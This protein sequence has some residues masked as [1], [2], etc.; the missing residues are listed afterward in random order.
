MVTLTPHP[1]IMQFNRIKLLL[2]LEFLKSKAE[3]QHSDGNFRTKAVMF[4][5]KP[6]D[7]LV[8]DI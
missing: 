6:T 7:V 2:S 3:K 8:V 5:C 1:Y 4:V